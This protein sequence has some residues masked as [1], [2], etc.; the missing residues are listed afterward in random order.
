[1][2]AAIPSRM[3]RVRSTRSI[4]FMAALAVSVTNAGAGTSAWKGTGTTATPV[5]NVNWNASGAWDTGT[6]ATGD[7][8]TF[9]GTGAAAY[10]SNNNL[11][12]TPALIT[13][14]SSASVG[15]NITGNN[16]GATSN[17]TIT[18][19]GTGA[20]NI[21]NA[22]GFSSN[23]NFTYTF[24][25][26]GSGLVTYSGAFSGRNGG[27]PATVAKS[28][29][30]TLLLTGTVGNNVSGTSLTGGLLRFG[31]L[32]SLPGN[33]TVGNGA[34]LGL[35]NNINLGARLVAGSTGIVAL[36]VNNN[37]L[38]DV[39][40]SSAFVG[41]LGNYTLSKAGFVA[42]AGST[43]RFG[44]AGGTLTVDQTNT[45]TGANALL[46]GSSQTNGSGTVLLSAANNYTAG[47]TINAG[48]LIVTQ[49]SA[50]GT[51]SV[52]NNATLD[53]GNS[54]SAVSLNIGSSAFTQA[55]AGTLKIHST[56]SSIGK[57]VSTN[58]TFTIN[59]GTM[60]TTGSLPTASS[61]R[62]KLLDTA[63]TRMGQ[64][65]SYNFA[66][67][68]T[69]NVSPASNKFVDTSRLDRHVSTAQ[70]AGE[71]GVLNF[72]DGMELTNSSDSTTTPIYTNYW[73]TNAST[74]KTVDSYVLGAPTSAG[75][76]T[77]NT[78]TANAAANKS[79]GVASTVARTIS[80]GGPFPSSANVGPLTRFHGEGGS[81]G[82][83]TSN[84]VA[85]GGSFTGFTT[86]ADVYLDP[87]WTGTSNGTGF[88][89]SVAI[90][91]AS[92][93]H[94][95]D[96]IFHAVKDGAGLNL[97]ADSNSAYRP[98]LGNSGASIHNIAS[99]GWYTLQHVFRD[100]GSGILA[101]DLK[102]FDAAG[103]HLWTETRLNSADA[104]SAVRGPF[105]GW[106]VDIDITGG[107]RV[108]NVKLIN[109]GITSGNP[110]TG[111]TGI[112]GNVTIG[113]DLAEFQLG[114]TSAGSAIDGYDV[115]RSTRGIATLN[116]DLMVELL[117]GFVPDADDTF[118]ILSAQ[119]LAGAFNN[120][121]NGGD[122][123]TPDGLGSFTANY[124]ASG[125][126]T[127]LVLSNFT[128][129]PEPGSLSL[130]LIGAPMLLKRRR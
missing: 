31:A 41:A 75:L 20:F 12:I 14:N 120:V 53:I 13:L 94:R 55:A 67:Q 92:G 101:V 37:T 6:P 71:I 111:G 49:G 36:N 103:T 22:L 33:V 97:G 90:A 51:G 18:Q 61:T 96:F 2:F 89:W 26:N 28:G 5:G 57:I 27:H 81:A 98:T 3:L 68:T 107:L 117:P 121:T 4:L 9:G 34:I 126:F 16:L 59:G 44:G 70:Q 43:Y 65:D 72:F 30:S 129:L 56:G 69:N 99:A 64:F 63:G 23:D 79:Y 11:S 93:N 8:L 66:G 86:Q 95:R 122:V 100:N 50:M 84:S 130:L 32:T 73:Q 42:G 87:A 21:S 54:A 88:D 112:E 113:G 25:G 127:N 24:S 15:E 47:T 106:F 115:L 102:L 118:T 77:R 45:F 119:S 128:A 7:T 83:A 82:F 39:N 105:Y 110:L 76:M 17:V 80:L 38:A 124:I 74:G 104:I 125:G 48:T 78:T 1:M 85:S 52:T 58:G 108:D 29:T 116:G 10:T 114:G 46:V 123:L 62:Y 91:D 19:N 60:Q 109:S 40:V 35:D